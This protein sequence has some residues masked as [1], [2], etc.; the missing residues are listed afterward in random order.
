M[1]TGNRMGIDIG[2]TTISIVL[3]DGESGKLTARET[4]DHDS[5]LPDETPG[6]SVQDP[7][8]ILAAATQK[9]KEMIRSYGR[10]EGIGVTGQM[11]GMLYVD[12]AGNAISPLYTW[13]DGRG[14]L[15]LRGG[16][17]AVELLK[18]KTEDPG[19][20][21]SGY[22]IVTHYYLGETGGIPEN[23]VKMTTIGDYVAMKLCGRESPLIGADMAASWGC[24]DLEKKEFRYEELARAGVEIAY[25]PQA[26]KRHCLMGN[27]IEAE[28]IPAGIPVTLAIGDNQ[29]SF[30][31]AAGQYPDAVLLNVGTGSQISFLSERYV[32]WE[33]PIELRP[34]TEDTYLLVGA[35]LCGGRAYAM[36]EQ[37]YREVAGNGA[38]GYY[39][40]MYRQAR[41]FIEKYGAQAA[42]D[43]RTTF[44]GTRK[45][46]EE[47]GQI[48]NIGAEN[49]H[50]GAMTVGVMK[51]I[52]Q[53][54]YEQYRIMSRLTGKTAACLVG[55]GNGIRRNPIMRELAEDLFGLPMMIPEYAEEA[56]CGAVRRLVDLL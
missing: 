55:S 1:S 33:D 24:Y 48:R 40:T 23:A 6:A 9:I 10:P 8:R 37:F 12:E 43:V 28:N 30:L 45:N 18:E 52:L 36:L 5:F 50:P 51:G 4:L 19:L 16:R 31:G 11:H 34:C 26:E 27:T 14:N 46:P 41:E 49:F 29:A 56:A 3:L 2:T 32:P 47:R 22:G 44:S 39:D 54:L 25:L 35:S 15:P 20:L 13:Q 42:W 53:E 21:A 7:E 17:S 38:G